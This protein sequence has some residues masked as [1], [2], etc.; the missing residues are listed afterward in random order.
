M[1]FSQFVPPS[2]SPTGSTSLFSMSASGT[3]CLLIKITYLV[4]GLA[5]SKVLYVSVQK[6]FSEKQ[7]DRQEVVVL[8]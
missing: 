4:S 6:E 8:I 7:S 5:E 3:P 2:A 1:L